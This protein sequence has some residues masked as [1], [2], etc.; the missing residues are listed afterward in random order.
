[1]TLKS[2]LIALMVIAIWGSNFAVIKIGVEAFEPLMFLA[3]RFT[4]AGL[5]F[6]PFVKWPGWHKAGQIASI[7]LLMGLLHQGFLYVGLQY[8]S[9]GTMSIILQV[10]VIIVTLI[11]WLF[12]KEKIGWRTWTGITIAMV[13]IF[14]LVY[15]PDNQST[16]LGYMLGFFSAFFMAFAYLMMKKID[17]VPATTYM[18]FLHL[19]IAPF[20][21]LSSLLF[22]GTEWMHHTANLNWHVITAVILYQAI[23]MS[24]SHIV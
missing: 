6:L 11:G 23:V 14:I 18:V 24:I 20:I 7:G 21:L 13:G 1:M 4:L 22:E 5:I 15:K 2:T 9:A 8:M 10:N 3:A 19:P 12:L 16:P 17:K